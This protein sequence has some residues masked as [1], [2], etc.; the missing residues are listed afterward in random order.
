M[1]RVE[2][3]TTVERARRNPVRGSSCGTGA[4]RKGQGRTQLIGSAI[5]LFADRGFEAVSPKE[6]AAAAGLT[7]GSVY[8]HFPGKSALY[9]AAV[10]SALEELPQAPAWNRADAVPPRA[11]LEELV[12]WFTI[13]ISADT[14][15]AKLLRRE[16]TNPGL[17]KA[18][19]EFET[20]KGTSAHFAWLLSMIDPDANAALAEAAINSL[21]FGIVGLPGLRRIAPG[22]VFSSKSAEEIAATVC[23]IVLDGVAKVGRNS[24]FEQIAR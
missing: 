21:L 15:V 1:S 9:E 16:F 22:T 8:H 20:F 10:L 19:S 2:T 3:N 7:I 17:S 11:A 12:K 5:R 4:Q 6:I 13:V 14:P 24:G 23:T 18:I